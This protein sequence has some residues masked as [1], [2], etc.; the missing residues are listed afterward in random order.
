MI[1]NSSE[2][3]ISSLLCDLTL[4][5]HFEV[6]PMWAFHYFYH[7]NLPLQSEWDIKTISFMPGIG[8]R[9]GLH[10]FQ[11]IFS[12]A[13]HNLVVFPNF[14]RIHF[15]FTNFVPTCSK[16]SHTLW[17]YLLSSESAADSSLGLPFI[18]CTEAE[19]GLVNSS[20]FTFCKCI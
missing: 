1:T 15:L 2:Q 10:R 11:I 12:N 3:L 8:G 5:H 17:V 13:V 16:S 9:I 14:L 20:L 18:N 6:H 19:A 7:C 4:T